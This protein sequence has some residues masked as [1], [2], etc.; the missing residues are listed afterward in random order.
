[1][2]P[3]AEPA[4]LNDRRGRE[5][6][7]WSSSTCLASTPAETRE[8]I[9][10]RP[11]VNTVEA[12]MGGTRSSSSPAT[13]PAIDEETRASQTGNRKSRGLGCGD[14]QREK[15]SGTH[16]LLLGTA[17]WAEGQFRSIKGS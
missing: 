9:Q 4:P 12:C 15:L 8:R 13:T 11:E 2:E 3:G 5:A 17:R 1:M 7:R 16:A 14:C 6:E 10:P